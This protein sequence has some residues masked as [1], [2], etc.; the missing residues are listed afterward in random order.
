MFS[1]HGTNP[2]AEARDEHHLGCGWTAKLLHT[3]PEAE[4]GAWVAWSLLCVLPLPGVGPQGKSG[5]KKLGTSSIP[6]R[7][8]RRRL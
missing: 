4:Q 1:S 8:W 3:W 2:E 6:C 7:I 5:Q